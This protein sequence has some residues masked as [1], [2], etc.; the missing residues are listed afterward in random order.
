MMSWVSFN[1]LPLS[2]SLRQKIKYTRR[3]LKSKEGSQKNG[4]FI[5]NKVLFFIIAIKKLGAADFNDF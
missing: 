3:L 1:Y 5:L 4:K 2:G